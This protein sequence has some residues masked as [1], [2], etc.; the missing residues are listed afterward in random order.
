MTN[1]PLAIILLW[2]AATM[3]IQSGV[4]LYFSKTLLP[5][6]QKARFWILMAAN[7]A[8]FLLT[9]LVYR[10][11]LPLTDAW[12]IASREQGSM[13]VTVMLLILVYFLWMAPIIGIRG[14]VVQEWLLGDAIREKRQSWWGYAAIGTITSALLLGAL[15]IALTIVPPLMTGMDSPRG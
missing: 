8:A 13:A 7:G 2:V 10:L 14:Y 15:Y 11:T 3:S 9:G 5:G 6:T 4:D 12:L 1:L